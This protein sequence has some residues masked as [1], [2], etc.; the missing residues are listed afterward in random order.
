MPRARP[1]GYL[2]RYNLMR[3]K[4]M[5][6]ISHLFYRLCVA[7]RPVEE[8]VPALRSWT[9]GAKARVPGQEV[10]YSN[11]TPLPDPPLEL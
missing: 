5:E 11:G 9:G 1:S 8:Q 4:P 6:V 3:A 2:E 7:H 10:L